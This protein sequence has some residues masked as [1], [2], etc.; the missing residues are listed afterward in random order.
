MENVGPALLLLLGIS[1]LL[2][3]YMIY[4]FFE[5]RS[6]LRF[7]SPKNKWT[8][9]IALLLIIVA[10]ANYFMN[11]QNLE[12]LF[13]AI[14]VMIF[15]IAMV[16]GKSGIGE[17]GIYIEGI[18]ISWKQITKASVKEEK[19]KVIF[20]YDRKKSQRSMELTNTNAEEVETYLRKKRKI[21]H[22]GK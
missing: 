4:I 20:A 15:A 7:A 10:F 16:I 2:F 22:F 1:V 17:T 12:N 8:P 11:E 9:L 18:K 6:N 21:Y 3:I 14:V 5:Q 13:A 19:G